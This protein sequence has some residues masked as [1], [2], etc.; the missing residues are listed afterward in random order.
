MNEKKPQEFQLYDFMKDPRFQ[1]METSLEY[2]DFFMTVKQD[3]LVKL[4]SIQCSITSAKLSISQIEA[5]EILNT[6]FKKEYGKDNEDIRKAHLK[7]VTEELQLQLAGYNYQKSVYK[8][9]LDALND[10]I[11]SNQI[12]LGEHTCNCHGDDGV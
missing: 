5:D 2:I 6:D 3:V 4:D 8:N 9:M 11:K 12:L 10:M 7:K 1:Q